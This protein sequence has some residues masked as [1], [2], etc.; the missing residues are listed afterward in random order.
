MHHG[1]IRMRVRRASCTSGLQRP[2]RTDPQP[3]RSISNSGA[4]MDRRAFLADLSR[5]AF[6]CAGVPGDWRVARQ[7]PFVADPFALG[8]ASGDPTPDACVIWTRLAPEP[9]APLGGMNG[10]KTF[11]RWE[12]AHDEAFTRVVRQGRYTAAPELG[13]SVHVD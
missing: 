11:V 13:Y 9:L 3:R 7:F 12:V 1:C 8:I 6:L 10:Q 4:G 2:G 5:Y